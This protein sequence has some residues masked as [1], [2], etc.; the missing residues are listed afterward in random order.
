MSHFTRL[1]A[2]LVLIAIVGTC[3]W[4]FFPRKENGVDIDF[5]VGVTA[6]S[7]AMVT[8]FGILGPDRSTKERSSL[9]GDRLRTAIACSLII[10]YIYMVSFTAFVWNP[11]EVG[12]VT[13]T[14]VESFSSV[15][16][17]TIAF[18]FGASAAAQIFGTEKEPPLAGKRADEKGPDS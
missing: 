4:A 2:G 6:F 8:F 5:V 13:R 12:E 15:I 17:I 16:G 18:Y 11:P 7:I 9:G 1:G 3:I 14:F 10:T